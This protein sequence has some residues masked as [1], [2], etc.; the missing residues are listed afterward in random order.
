MG[1]G[2]GDE[3]FDRNFFWIGNLKVPPTKLL[4]ILEPE[5]KSVEM[6]IICERGDVKGV[7]LVSRSRPITRSFLFR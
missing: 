2:S 6:Y 1:E 5:S 4:M 7:E 3:R